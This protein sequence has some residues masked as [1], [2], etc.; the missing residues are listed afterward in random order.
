[1]TGSRNPHA[2]NSLARL[3]RPVVRRLLSLAA[4]LALTRFAWLPYLQTHDVFPAKLALARVYF[5]GAIGMIHVLSVLLPYV[6]TLIAFLWT[7]WLLARGLRYAAQRWGGYIDDARRRR[8]LRRWTGRALLVF[9]VALTLPSAVALGMSLSYEARGGWRG[10]YQRVC[11][12]CHTELR[13]LSR[14]QPRQAW[15]LVVARMQAKNPEAISDADKQAA[16]NY[17]NA[18]RSW[19]GEELLAGKCTVCH[20]DSF[21]DRPRPADEWERIVDRASRYNVFF[22][23]PMHAEQ[24]VAAIKCSEMTQPADE[25]DADRPLRTLYETRCLPCH[26][27]DIIVTANPPDAQWPALLDRMREKAPWLLND[28]EAQSLVPWIRAMRADRD[29]FRRD[30]PHQSHTMFFGAEP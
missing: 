23:T 4:A 6:V 20:D 19:S 28:A 16:L 5:V 26:T 7:W 22:I 17:L 21:R 10:D 2:P 27:L 30:V 15:E 12:Q 18:V 8:P 29:R 11:S 9:A 24:I 13:A 25:G 3:G 1:M 14:V